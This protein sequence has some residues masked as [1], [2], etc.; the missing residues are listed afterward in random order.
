MVAL[1][2]SRSASPARDRA[3]A[4]VKWRRNWPA[5]LSLLPAAIIVAV[6]YLGTMLW[7]VMLSFTSSKTLPSFEFVGWAQYNR[8]FNTERF[9]ASAWH[10]L[11]FGVL[12]VAFCLVLGFLLAVLIDQKIRFESAFRTIY[13]YPF[14][15]SFIVT[16]LIWQ[17]LLHPELGLEKAVRD[18]GFTSFS[19]NWIVDNDKV[20]YTLVIAAVWQASGLV[21]ALMLAGL[22]GVDAEIWKAAR[23]DAIPT[24]RVYVSIILPMITPMIVA[25][26]VLLAVGVARLYDL[27]VAMTKGGPGI[28]S[29]MPAKFIMDNFFERANVGLGSAAATVQLVAVIVA[30]APWV[31]LEHL[32]PRRRSR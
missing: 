29:E 19:F 8:L 18:L 7:T 27:V 23:V 2:V 30:L 25:A 16:G 15:M 5:A 14:S 6:I 31:Y 9:T 1:S 32:R 11:I 26:T 17:W 4:L 13:L 24:W 10:I 12:F 3:A 28:S 22:R 20:V 21:M